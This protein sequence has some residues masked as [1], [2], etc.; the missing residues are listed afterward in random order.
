MYS[1]FRYNERMGLDTVKL[2]ARLEELIAEENS[3]KAEFEE[4]EKELSKMYK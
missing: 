1:H 3:V 4:K 2:N